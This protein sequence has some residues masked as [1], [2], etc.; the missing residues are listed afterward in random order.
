MTIYCGITK[1]HRSESSLTWRLV[2][3][4]YLSR[5][6]FYELFE[7]IF[8]KKVPDAI[9]AKLESAEDVRDKITLGM[10]W[11][12]ADARVALT[13]VVDFA[14][15]FNAFVSREAGFKPFGDLRGYKG[16]AEPLTKAT[17]RWILLGM[18]IPKRVEG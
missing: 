12:A 13:N 2:S 11:S 1:L 4:D 18:G 16:P 5:A 8:G 15:E 17:T 6:R 14:D 10:S 3:E 7:R 9:R